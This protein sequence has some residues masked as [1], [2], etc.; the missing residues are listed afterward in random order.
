MAYIPHEEQEKNLD[1]LILLLYTNN[2][3]TRHASGFIMRNPA[4]LL[5]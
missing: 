2:N 1:F 4:G 5:F 3:R